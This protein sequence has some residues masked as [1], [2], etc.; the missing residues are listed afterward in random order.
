MGRE[1][2][3]K[4]LKRGGQPGRTKGVP[5]RATVEV[6]AWARSV[7]EDPTV[8]QIT[9]LQAQQGRLPSPIMQELF[10]RAYGKVKDQMELSGEPSPIR[11]IEVVVPDVR[12]TA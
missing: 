7:L 4:N 6:R 9:L 3:L 1:R 8:R 2:S 12:E 11:V 10:N 5:N